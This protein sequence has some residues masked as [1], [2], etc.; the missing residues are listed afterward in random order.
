MRIVHVSDGYLPRRGGIEYHVHDLA[1][2]QV[3]TGDDVAVITSTPGTTAEN[4]AFPVYRPQWDPRATPSEGMQHTW[5]RRALHHLRSVSADVVHIHTSTVSPLAFAAIQAAS[6]SGVTP[7]VTMHSVVARGRPLLASMSGVL[8]WRRCPAVW[9][10]VSVA[11]AQDLRRALGAWCDVAV[12]PNG[13]DVPA[14]K[15]APHRR[16]PAHLVMASSGRLAPRKRIRPLLHMMRA[17]RRR[18]DSGIRLELLLAGDGPERSAV[19]RYVARHGMR[20]WVT[21]TGARTREELREHYRHVDLYIAPAR[22]E[23]FGLAALE[24]RCA[25]LPVIAYAG[26]GV[27]DFVT[28]GRDGLLTGSDAAMTDEIVRLACD[29]PAHDRLSEA[30]ST[31]VP[32]YSWDEVLPLTYATYDRAVALRGRAVSA[33]RR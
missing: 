27:A 17:A 7:V 32:P 19:E 29:P 13:A 23:S 10:A 9:T 22:L 31:F 2:R 33:D 30:A 28:N 15:L 3:A 18:V 12:L 5:L 11:A 6:R 8:G 20:D 21:L 14:W 1:R 26:T 25:G 24:A 16:D 4:A